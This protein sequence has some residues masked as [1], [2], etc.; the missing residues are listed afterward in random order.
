MVPPTVPHRTR[1][2]KAPAEADKRRNLIPIDA[3]L[4]EALPDLLEKFN[5]WESNSH[6][7]SKATTLAAINEFRDAIEPATGNTNSV[8]L[9][10]HGDL[11]DSA[12]E[13]KINSFL[14]EGDYSLFMVER[15]E[16]SIFRL[17][18]INSTIDKTTRIDQNIEDFYTIDDTQ[19]SLLHSLTND[20][21]CYYSVNPDEFSFS[22]APTPPTA[23]SSP[24]AMDSATLLS[25][26]TTIMS[27]ANLNA[28]DTQKALLEQLN[29]VTNQVPDSKSS[30]T[31]HL[32]NLEGIFYPQ[33]HYITSCLSP[34]G[35]PNLILTHRNFRKT[36]ANLPDTDKPTMSDE[37]ALKNAL[38]LFNDQGSNDASLNDYRPKGS[39]PISTIESFVTANHYIRIL[40]CGFFG[41]HLREP[42][43]HL[44]CEL[45]DIHRRF[46]IPFAKLV[47][48][49]DIKMS[50]LRTNFRDSTSDPR[51]FVED[52]LH[53]NDSDM[54]LIQ[55]IYRQQSVLFQL[56]SQK[57]IAEALKKK[58]D[59]KIKAAQPTSDK[60]TPKPSPTAQ[61]RTALPKL[62][63]SSATEEICFSWIR[64]KCPTSPC[65][66]NRSHQFDTVANSA[67]LIAE[68]KAAV[69]R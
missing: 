22:T 62:L 42:L 39:P 66:H 53:I 29:K 36:L 45:L 44:M 1:S 63:G 20:G 59:P 52:S 61:K 7:Q 54:S 8:V 34:E 57:D 26:I 24:A 40:M 28:Q 43:E 67:A 48:V 18:L 50:S 27:S 41:S 68:Y 5:S 10:I 14:S 13:T 31:Q 23:S 55:E 6:A 46:G 30:S 21:L 12:R 15:V 19:M 9:L 3:S 38:L 51:D 16:E 35:R 33:N 37:V 64:G 25:M 4:I 2:K 69:I 58:G 47:M 17:H 56:Q 49:F 32:Q 65:P 60:K 11:P